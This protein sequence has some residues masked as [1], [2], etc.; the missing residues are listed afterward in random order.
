V[1]TD[2]STEFGLEKVGLIQYLKFIVS[3]NTTLSIW[4]TTLSIE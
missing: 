3:G 4:D 1:F 2:K